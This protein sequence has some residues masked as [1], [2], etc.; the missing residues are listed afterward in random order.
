[1]LQVTQQDHSLLPA[2]SA[3]QRIGFEFPAHFRPLGVII[4]QAT[5]IMGKMDA[6]HPWWFA[7]GHGG[8]GRGDGGRHTAG[9][10]IVTAIHEI[11]SVLNHLQDTMN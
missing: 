9:P 8:K 3:N 4:D 5:E 2:V 6:G 10:A 1:M 7:V 11:R